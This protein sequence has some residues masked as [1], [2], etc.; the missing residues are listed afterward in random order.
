M[1]RDNKLNPP[2][3]EPLLDIDFYGH[4]CICEVHNQYCTF[5]CKKCT[6]KPLCESCWRV[7]AEAEH[8]LHLFLQIFKV[9][10]KASVRKADIESEVD[11]RKIQPYIINNHKVILLKPKG[12]NGGNPKCVI[13]QGKIKDEFY[14]YCSISCKIIGDIDQLEIVEENGPRKRRKRRPC[15]S[16]LF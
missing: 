3:L 1:E 8:E 4:N 16:P 15:R 10:E 2:W 5:F 11:V 13:C 14:Q 9:S 12:G 6:N 7:D